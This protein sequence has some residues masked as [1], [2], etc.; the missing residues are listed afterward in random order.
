MELTMLKGKIH[1]VKVTKA[2]LNYEGSIT[3]DQDLLKNLDALV[4]EQIF[5]NRSQAFQ[6][7]VR[8][9]LKHFSHADLIRECAKLDQ[10]EER[11]MADEGL[12]EDLKEWPIY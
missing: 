11:A 1:R 7:S 8:L 4:A 2:G 9:Q 5:K 10:G 12:E 6:E 3:V